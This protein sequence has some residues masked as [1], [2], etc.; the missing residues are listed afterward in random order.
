MP[1]TPAAPALDPRLT[2]RF[3]VASGLNGLVFGLEISALPLYFLSLG[4]PPPLYGLLVGLAW[5]VSLVVRIPIGALAL[6]LGNRTLFRVGCWAFAPLSWALALAGSVPLFFAIRLLNGMARSLMVLPLRSWFTELCPR[7][8]LAA[9][10]GRLNASFALG[11][12]LL[13]LLGG[14]VLLTALGPVPFLALLGAL[15][16]LI[17]W[18][19]L[20]APPDHPAASARAAAGKAAPQLLWA[21]AL[22]GLA[23][24]AGLSAH[25]AFIPQIVHEHGWPP[26]TVGLLLFI[27]GATTVLLAHHNG[28]LVARWGEAAPALTG[29]GLALL[30]AGTLYGIQTGAVLPLV[31]ALTGA[32]AGML[33]TLAMG[34]AAR[35]LPS[36]SQGISVH[37]TYTSLGLGAGGFL[38]GLTTAWL[39]TPHAALLCCVPF[40]LGGLAAV[41]HVRDRL[42]PAG[43]G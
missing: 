3:L 23:A 32:A 41:L 11:Q 30:A 8:R 33:P 7:P 42:E 17:W 39:G 4:L 21:G 35:A 29:L 43:R 9:E 14:P 2:Q 38:G 12:S 6:R 20:P 13:G 27:Q 5:L 25:A 40:A 16:L 31:A 26:P 1:S 37:E 34:L 10:L 19:L 18:L 36:R 22:C 15:P 24:N 28:P